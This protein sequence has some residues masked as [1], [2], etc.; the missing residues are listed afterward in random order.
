MWVE[1]VGDGFRFG[2]SSEH[3]DGY[4]VGLKELTRG[5]QWKWYYQV[6]FVLD[7]Y[8]ATALTLYLTTILSHEQ[9]YDDGL[10]PKCVAVPVFYRDGKLISAIR[11]SPIYLRLL[12]HEVKIFM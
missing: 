12:F 10:I 5:K 7:R 2:Q 11:F 4:L 1:V 6:W 3:V 8:V 9:V